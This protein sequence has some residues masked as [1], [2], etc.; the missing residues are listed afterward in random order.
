M[1]VQC[2]GHRIA[3]Q[4][5]CVCMRTDVSA[6][7]RECKGHSQT[8]CVCVYIYGCVSTE[9]GGACMRLQG[10]SRTVGGHMRVQSA[11]T[12]GGVSAQSS[13]GVEVPD[14]VLTESKF[15]KRAVTSFDAMVKLANKVQASRRLDGQASSFDKQNVR[16]QDTKGLSWERESKKSNDKKAM[17]RTTK[18]KKDRGKR[19]RSVEPKLPSTGKNTPCTRCLRN[20]AGG[21]DNC[22]AQLNVVGNPITAPPTEKPPNCHKCGQDGHE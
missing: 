19:S 6:L 7:A 10:H 3:G 17:K 22:W 2:K 9:L 15:M 4:I 8:V 16:A 14:R 5:V 18:E 1:R 20:H 21:K 12:N 11:N 13:L